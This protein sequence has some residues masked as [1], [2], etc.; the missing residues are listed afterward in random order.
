[1]L[2]PRFG[3]HGRHAAGPHQKLRYLG[4]TAVALGNFA[5]A[6]EGYC[7]AALLLPQLAWHGLSG[8]ARENHLAEWSGLASDAAAC[9]ILAGEPERAVEI[10]EQGRMIIQNQ[11]LHTR[12]I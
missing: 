9:Y 12:V 10:L 6:A 5:L 2:P 7:R 3:Y 4:Q 11:S 1:M 8:R